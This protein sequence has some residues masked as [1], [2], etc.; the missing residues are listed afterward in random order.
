MED[1]QR[2]GRKYMEAISSVH[3]VITVIRLLLFMKLKRGEALL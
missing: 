3:R 1:E 2:E